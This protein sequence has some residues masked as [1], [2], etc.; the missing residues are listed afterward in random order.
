M[1]GSN[2]PSCITSCCG[3]GLSSS[4]V[5]QL[6]VAN[7]RKN[8]INCLS[9]LK[10]LLELLEDKIHTDDDVGLVLGA[11]QCLCDLSCHLCIRL[12]AVSDP[13]LF[14]PDQGL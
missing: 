3:T 5:G 8:V 4:C 2:T 12:M 1:G 10:S 13:V 6:L 7:L 9:L 11:M 14:C